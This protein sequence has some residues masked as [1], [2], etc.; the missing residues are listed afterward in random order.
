MPG[1]DGGPRRP[2]Y[3]PVQ[4]ERL[5]KKTPERPAG[6]GLSLPLRGRNLSGGPL[7]QGEAGARIRACVWASSSCT[8]RQ[9]QTFSVLESLVPKDQSVIQCPVSRG[10]RGRLW[11]MRE[12]LE[13]RRK[14]ESWVPAAPTPGP[15]GPH[16]NTL[17]MRNAHPRL[18]PRAWG[19]WLLI[20]F[21]KLH[22]LQ[23]Q[24]EGQAPAGA[25]CVCHDSS[26]RLQSPQK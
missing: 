9:P 8:G 1:E 5:T 13:S 2:R 6:S 16:P 25:M 3:L 19:S 18:L 26:D 20:H 12:A 14:A 23:Q 24:E 17:E 22:F 10:S 21:E 4:T 15:R 7:S 11:W